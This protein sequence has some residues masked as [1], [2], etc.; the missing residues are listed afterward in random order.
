MQVKNRLFPYPVINHNKILSNFGTSDFVLLFEKEE[1]DKAFIMKNARFYTESKLINQLYDDGK[2]K[3]SCVIEC[4]Y[5][6]YRKA[7][8]LGK[9]GKDLILSKVDFNER[10]DVSMFATATQDFEL[11]SD[12]LDDDYAG[13]TF[14]LEKYDIIGANDG[15]NVRFKHEESE[16]NLAQ[17]IFSIITSHDFTPGAYTVE[18]N[19]GK[20]IVVTMSDKDY[21]N[22]KV[23]Y[24]VPAYKEVFFNMLLVPAL[25][26][27][28]TLCKTYL[29]EDSSRDL[30]DVGNQYLWFR[31]IVKSYKRL[32]GIDLSIDEFTRVSLAFF[33]QELLGK[34]LG[35]SLSKLVQEINREVGGDDNE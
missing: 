18:C 20:K 35:E 10:V 7:F 21:K 16:E 31:S 1:T 28:L 34:P 25:I 32:K 9:T 13:I 27:G 5:T 4:S 26:E 2:I 29:L 14:E 15:F 11:V 22:Y 17:S 23:I 30:E 3:I 12:E 33:A 19:T 8:E 24:T 6:V